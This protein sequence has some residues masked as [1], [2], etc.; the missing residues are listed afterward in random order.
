[1]SVMTA[2]EMIQAAIAAHPDRRITF[3]EFMQLALYHPEL[4]YYSNRARQIGASGDFFTSSHLGSAFGELLAEQ[5]VQM[6]EILD[7]PQP[8]TLVEMGAGQGL[9]AQDIISAIAQ[10]APDCL[11]H[12]DYVIVE[13]APGLIEVQQQQLR[14]WGTK[15][16]WQSLDELALNPIVGCCFSNE[17]LDA[18]A[19]HQV[20]FVASQLQEVYVTV[21]DRQFIEVLADPSTP[22]LAT[23][24]DQFATPPVGD[25]YPDRYRTEV[26]LAALTWV[27]QVAAALQQGYVLTIDYGYPA[28]RYYSPVRAHGTLQCY[29]Q[30]GRHNDP[31]QNVGQQDITAHV[32]FTAIE[33]QGSAC[34]L[35]TIGLT[36]QSIFLMALGLGERI[37]AVGQS[38]SRDPQ[39][40][41]DRLKQR[42]MLHQL[43]NPMGLGNFG[44]LIQSQ[45]LLPEMASVTLKGLNSPIGLGYF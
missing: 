20:E 34:G 23:Y 14:D 21:Q 2:A 9:L 27:K 36:Q 6:W 8:F 39:E 24:F 12:L 28:E 33:R 29:Y 16:R 1:M 19:V 35:E 15:I 4:G 32:N 42:D 30:H 3:A 22:E 7:R 11:A 25:R 10:Q 45:K 17:L 5:F 41:L 31:Y 40:I 26:N 13:T 38:D 44:V 43:I 37:A 18:L